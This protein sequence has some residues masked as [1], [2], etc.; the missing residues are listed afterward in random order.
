MK[1]LFIILFICAGLSAKAQ[2]SAAYET[3]SID[4]L[5][6]DS[7]YLKITTIT[8]TDTPRKDTLIHYLLF[9]DTNDFITYVRGKEQELTS[10]GT[11]FSYLESEKDTLGS[12]YSRLLALGGYYESPFRSVLAPPEA[13]RAEQ[14]TAPGYWVIYPPSSKAEYVYDLSNLNCTCIVL[15]PDGTSEKR[16]KKKAKPTVKRE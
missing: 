7:F 16:K 5:S 3:Y 10:L 8:T 6:T 13:A 1:H 2:Y 11:R 4:S 12:R 15:H 9:K 14:V